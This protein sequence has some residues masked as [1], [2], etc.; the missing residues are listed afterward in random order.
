MVEEERDVEKERVELRDGRSG[1]EVCVIKPSETEGKSRKSKCQPCSA[2]G[3][4]PEGGEVQ[5]CVWEAVA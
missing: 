3:I 1:T 4:C 5:R 2:S